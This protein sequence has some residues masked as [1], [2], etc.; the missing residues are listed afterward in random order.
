MGVVEGV[1]AQR[2]LTVLETLSVSAPSVQES[3]R[4]A[5]AALR[6]AEQH[7]SIEQQRA[8]RKQLEGFSTSEF[9]RIEFPATLSPPER[10]FV[11]AWCEARSPAKH[12]SNAP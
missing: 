2:E 1:I 10:A 8:L 11:T 3:A 7:L 5:T 12:P 6:D 4:S 9:Q